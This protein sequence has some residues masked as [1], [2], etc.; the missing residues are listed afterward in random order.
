MNKTPAKITARVLFIMY[1]KEMYYNGYNYLYV[2]YEGYGLN[3]GKAHYLNIYDTGVKSPRKS[4]FLKNRLKKRGLTS[5][6]SRC[7]LQKVLIILAPR[8]V[9]LVGQNW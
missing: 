3:D 9:I 2:D 4:S 7:C 1:E 5:F 6:F 8:D